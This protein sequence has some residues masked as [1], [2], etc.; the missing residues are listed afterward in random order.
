MNQQK[1]CYNVSNSLD[2]PFEIFTIII[3]MTEFKLDHMTPEK[4]EF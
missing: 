4:D 3:C 1:L 2:P